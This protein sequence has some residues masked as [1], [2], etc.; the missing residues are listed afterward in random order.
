MQAVHSRSDE[1]SQ[2]GRTPRAF[3]FRHLAPRREKR[4]V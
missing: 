1:P 2:T 4:H 3:A